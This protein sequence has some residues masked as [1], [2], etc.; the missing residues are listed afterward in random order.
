[1]ECECEGYIRR[2]SEGAVLAPETRKSTL[3][4]LKKGKLATA[5]KIKH[6]IQFFGE[7]LKAFKDGFFGEEEDQNGEE[8][9]EEQENSDQ[10]EREEVVD[11]G[12]EKGRKGKEGRNF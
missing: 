8:S 6:E 1:M 5:L 12:P 9:E 4:E 11:K 2:T 3:P 10:E 7:N